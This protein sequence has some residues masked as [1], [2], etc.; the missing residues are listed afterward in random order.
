MLREMAFLREFCSRMT[1]LLWKA[2]E[3]FK[4]FGN[5]LPV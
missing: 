3:K 4:N 1:L 2:I 5:Q